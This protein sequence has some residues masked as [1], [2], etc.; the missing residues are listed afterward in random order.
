M[1]VIIKGEAA[2]RVS[3]AILGAML[4]A[5]FLFAP[6]LLVKATLPEIPRL[7]HWSALWQDR[8]EQL[9]Q[10]GAAN[11]DEVHVVEL[12]SIVNDIAELSPDPDYWY[13]NCAEMY[14]GIDAIYADQPG[15]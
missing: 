14:Y 8:H 6:F 2:R 13:N 3:F 12:D 7:L 4:I 15:W 1:A 5:T 9:I 11:A 10:A